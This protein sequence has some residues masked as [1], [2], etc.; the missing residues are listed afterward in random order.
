MRRFLLLTMLMFAVA[1]VGRAQ[2]YPHGVVYPRPTPAQLDSLLSLGIV[3]TWLGRDPSLYWPRS[4]F[5]VAARATWRTYMTQALGGGFGAEADIAIPLGTT[6]FGL[7]LYARANDYTVRSQGWLD[8][9]VQNGE[10]GV[11][12]NGGIG[13]SLAI[14]L[15]IRGFSFPLSMSVGSAF[16][17]PGRS[18]SPAE[19]YIGLEPSLG[20]RYRITPILSAQAMAQAAWMVPLREGNRGIGSW[21]F[22]AGVE[23]A[24]APYQQDALPR[25]VPA[26]VATAQD[27]I[28]LMGTQPEDELD[29]LDR[30][31]D[32]INTEVKP[33][34]GF[35]WYP[36]GF[37][38]KV[39]GTVESSSRAASG[40]VTALD[41]RLDSAD[42]YG[43]QVWRT[44]LLLDQKLATNYLVGNNPGDTSFLNTKQKVV[45]DRIKRGD[46][47]YRLPDMFGTRYLRA[48]LFPESKG[49]SLDMVPRVGSRVEV[50][51]ELWWDGDGHLELHPRRPSDIVLKTGQFL[52]AAD[53]FILE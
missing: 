22:S 42:R 17:Q 33:F 29:V 38:G 7:F 51:G 24:L 43:F 39:R 2:P 52:D 27:V 4:R 28:H 36:L 11:L 21:N 41:I 9:D 13:A 47:S 37:F 45:L 31:M 34:T 16:F 8:W 10:S 30:N 19:T 26:L 20:L 25:W 12:F 46:Y 40:N 50:A 35:G 15:Y 5:T 23:L 14:P 44:S 1:A 6:D 3:P 48:E 53:D 18:V 32:F 49:D